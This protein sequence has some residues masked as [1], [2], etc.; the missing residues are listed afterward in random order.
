MCRSKMQLASAT[1][2]FI[3]FKQISHK[4]HPAKTRRKHIPQT[5]G[6]WIKTLPVLI[7]YRVRH[8]PGTRLFK[9]LP[10]YSI[11]TNIQDT[12]KVNRLE[13]HLSSLLC[14]AESQQAEFP[15]RVNCS[16][17][18]WNLHSF[19]SIPAL[20]PVLLWWNWAAVGNQKSVRFT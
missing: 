9:Y 15:G 6:S 18:P 19:S 4:I 8:S 16:E 7:K 13:K 2:H 11:I 14:S 10:V 12:F 17:V 3:I 5:K 20:T 1:V